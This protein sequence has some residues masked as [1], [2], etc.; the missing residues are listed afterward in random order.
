MTQFGQLELR[1][2]ELSSPASHTTQVEILN[3]LLQ[4]VSVEVKLCWE[5]ERQ[6]ELIEIWSKKLFLKNG[7][8]PEFH[9]PPFKCDGHRCKTCISD[10]V[11]Y[12]RVRNSFYGIAAA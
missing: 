4:L 1:N 2:I 11:A 6:E 10:K 8:M 9:A 5:W 7:I 12:R 3:F